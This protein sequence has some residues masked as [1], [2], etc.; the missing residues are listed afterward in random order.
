VSRRQIV[1]G[2]SKKKRL[3]NKHNPIFHYRSGGRQ[4]A[5]KNQDKELK[6]LGEGE[7]DPRE[8]EK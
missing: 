8:R 4:H 3:N 1:K 6:K 7:R 2:I 5:A